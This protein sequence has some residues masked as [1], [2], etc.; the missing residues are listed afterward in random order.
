MCKYL[1]KI[2]CVL[3]MLS[4]SLAC[5]ESNLRLQ[6]S[7]AGNTGNPS[8]SDNDT[9]GENTGNTGGSSANPMIKQ[10][11]G[12]WQ[13]VNNNRSSIYFLDDAEG[14][15]ESLKSYGGINWNPFTWRV[16][17]STVYLK[18]ASSGKEY[19]YDIEFDGDGNL[20]L[21]SDSYKNTYRRISASGT[22]TVNYKKPPYPNYICIYG[23]YYE[24]LEV[25][26]RSDH[27][28]S[29]EANM[30]HLF[31]FGENGSMEPIGARFMYATPYYEG[32]DRMWYAGNYKIDS[33][34]GYY[35]YGGLYCLNSSWSYRC[36]G[37]LT[38]KSSGN[39]MTFDFTLDDGDAVGHFSGTL[40]N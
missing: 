14:Y 20:I 40:S 23:Y 5:D 1:S 10:L 38:I 18:Y 30:K 22:T 24:I 35:V 17:D 33:D 4:V 11:I 21:G 36:D 27:A 25:K 16:E 32:I 28:Q 19:E 7:L 13:D 37:K 39:I 8:D 3:V 9:P 2:L 12:T 6:E 15:K 26:M 29:T 31:F 34:S